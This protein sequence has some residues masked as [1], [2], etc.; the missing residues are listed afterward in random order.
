[1]DANMNLHLT[2]MSLRARL[3]SLT[4]LILLAVSLALILILPSRIG[5]VLQQRM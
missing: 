3:V 1:M 5:E 2:A 4:S